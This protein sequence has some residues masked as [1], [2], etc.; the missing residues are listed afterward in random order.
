MQNSQSPLEKEQ[1]WGTHLYWFQ[2]LLTKLQLLRQ[3]DTGKRHI[4]QRN[5]I[6]SPELNTYVYSELIFN[7]CQG[8]SVQESTVFSKSYAETIGYQMQKNEVG[9]IPHTIHKN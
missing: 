4:D 3:Y 1:T 5:R 7:K 6:E 8:I 9:P 2:H